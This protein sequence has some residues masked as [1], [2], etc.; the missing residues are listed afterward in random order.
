MSS[1]S[2]DVDVSPHPPY[3]DSMRAG[4]SSILSS[5]LSKRSAT[6]GPAR[7]R[8]SL[9]IWSISIGKRRR[10][11]MALHSVGALLAIARGLGSDWSDGEASWRR[12][13]TAVC[14]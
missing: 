12:T 11:E 13:R 7:A 3:T 8:S 1:V 10:F 4:G 5:S 6:T 14:L 9:L 2:A